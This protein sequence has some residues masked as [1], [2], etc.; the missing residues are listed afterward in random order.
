MLLTKIRLKYRNVERLEVK[1]WQQINNTNTKKFD[2]GILMSKTDFKARSITRNTRDVAQG[3][4]GKST[5]KR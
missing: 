5:R 2:G 3:E 1:G 4:E